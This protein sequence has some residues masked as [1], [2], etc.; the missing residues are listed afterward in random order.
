MG[1]AVT[2]GRIVHYYDRGAYVPAMVSEVGKAE[3]GRT[4]VT[5]TV[6]S[7]AGSYIANN[8]PLFDAGLESIET[9]AETW[10]VWPPRGDATY[11]QVRKLGEQAELPP[12]DDVDPSV[13]EDGLDEALGRA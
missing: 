1:E 11:P 13:D 10:A 4:R 9:N 6:L 5:L 2:I 8:V 12:E 3:P 7:P